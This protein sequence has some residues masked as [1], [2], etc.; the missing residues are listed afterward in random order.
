MNFPQTTG[1]GGLIYP[2]LARDKYCYIGVCLK[3]MRNSIPIQSKVVKAS[4]WS[5]FARKSTLQPILKFSQF[6]Y[7]SESRWE[8][9]FL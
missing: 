4:L 8:P 6:I 2:F 5:R 3:G 9:N 1:K 7:S